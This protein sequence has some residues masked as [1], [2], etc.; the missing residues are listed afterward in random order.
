MICPVC[1]SDRF[2]CFDAATEGVAAGLTG[3]IC[4]C[5]IPNIRNRKR[6]ADMTGAEFGEALSDL[7]KIL[8]GEAAE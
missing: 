7:V 4:H 3:W 2:G 1:G 5:P 6:I 8:D